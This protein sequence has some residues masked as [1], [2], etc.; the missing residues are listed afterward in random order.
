M[1]TE[2]WKKLNINLHDFICK[3]FVGVVINTE[4][5]SNGLLIANIIQVPILLNKK[6]VNIFSY[7][8][9][10]QK[11]YKTF[12]YFYFCKL[13]INHEFNVY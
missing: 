2:Y 5:K 3:H 11:A 1:K 10:I 4:N 9:S 7:T 12:D 6:P 8:E 13:E